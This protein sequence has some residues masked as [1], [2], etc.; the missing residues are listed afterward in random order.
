MPGKK[1]EEHILLN[2]SRLFEEKMRR[3]GCAEEKVEKL[4]A[5]LTISSHKETSYSTHRK[6]KFFFEWKREWQCQDE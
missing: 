1:N 2:L 5:H 4:S 3:K 6:N